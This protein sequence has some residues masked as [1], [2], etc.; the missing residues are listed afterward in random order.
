[1]RMFLISDNVDTQTGMRL[2]GVKGVVVHEPDEFETA[3]SEA[4]SD[5]SNAIVLITEKLFN[6]MKDY[7]ME[8]KL[9]SPM[10]LIVKIPDRHGQTDSDAMMGYISEAMGIK[11]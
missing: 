7:I 10:P 2:A 1:M 3:L 8:R 4:L 11:F 6:L 9:K 5:K